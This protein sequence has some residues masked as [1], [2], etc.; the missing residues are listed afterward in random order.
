M[1]D[2][3]RQIWDRWSEDLKTGRAA[4]QSLM[5][6]HLDMMDGIQ[7]PQDTES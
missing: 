2:A 3:A 6:A 1:P 4:C 7:A 5:N